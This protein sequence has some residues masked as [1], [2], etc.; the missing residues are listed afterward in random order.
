[1]IFANK[2]YYILI[3]FLSSFNLFG[4]DSFSDQYNLAEKLYGDDNYYDA[5][6]ELKRLEFFDHSDQYSFKANFLIGKCYKQGAKFSDAI[7]FFVFAELNASNIDELY[8]AKEEVIRANILRRTTSRALALLDSLEND[9]RFGDKT[10]QI[11]Y[12]RGWVHIFANKWEKAAESFAMI[13]QEHE[14][15]TLCEK[16]DDEMYS[17]GFAKGISFL[18]PGT[19][20]FYTGEYVSGLLSLGWNVLWGY[21]TVRSLVDDRI[22][23]GLMTG[24]FLWMRFYNGNLQNAEKFAVEKNLEISNKS[25]RYLQYEYSG[26]KP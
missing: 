19:G 23:D 26:L 2:K 5:I 20:Q 16:T 25:L 1:M 8:S 18:I 13:S 15:K 21:L 10:D 9:K 4:Q 24:S 17:V 11:N 22:F 6:T 12:W 14:L 7:N 3:I